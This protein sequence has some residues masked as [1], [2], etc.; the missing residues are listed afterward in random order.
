MTGYNDSKESNSLIVYALRSNC[1]PI[2]LIPPAIP[3]Y[4]CPLGFCSQF[5]CS[6]KQAW[7]YGFAHC[8]QF[9]TLSREVTCNTVSSIF[10]PWKRKKHTSAQ[11]WLSTGPQCQTVWWLPYKYENTYIYINYR[12]VVNN[13]STWIIPKTIIC[14]VLDFQVL[15]IMCIYI[16]KYIFRDIHI[17]IDSHPGTTEDFLTHK[18]NKTSRLRKINAFSKSISRGKPW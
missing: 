1:S 5:S 17:Q 14:L 13:F 7:L 11:L 10:H 8:S 12:M 2:V 15:Y 6:K 16:Y 9:E 3:Q 18:P 4:G